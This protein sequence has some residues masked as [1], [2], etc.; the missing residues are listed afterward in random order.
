MFLYVYVYS[1][2]LRGL[3]IDSFTQDLFVAKTRRKWVRIKL[4]LGVAV[5]TTQWKLLAGGVP[6][7]TTLLG[8]RT[9]P[10]DVISLVQILM[11]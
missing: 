11:T 7:Q 4:Q 8:W 9:L 5:G 6:R 2:S 1:L 10:Q 3:T